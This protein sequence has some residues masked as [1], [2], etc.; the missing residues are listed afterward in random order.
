MRR[1]LLA[2]SLTASCLV[3][4]SALAQ[5]PAR[6]GGV[7]PAARPAASS[8]RTNEVQA[9][10]EMWFY[11]QERHRYDDPKTMV[12]QNAAF[13]AAQRKQRLT[14]MKWYGFSNSRPMVNSTPFGSSYA[15]TWTNASIRPWSFYSTT[16][17]VQVL[18]T[19]GR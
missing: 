19:F 18:N 5:N 2:F 4:S 16:R 8:V 7:A 12:R 13:D 10:P 9:T 3:A 11:E 14:A 15:P 6:P 1:L 17:Q